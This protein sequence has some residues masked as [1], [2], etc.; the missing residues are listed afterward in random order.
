MDPLTHT[1]VGA[2]LSATRLGEK[3]R[4]AAAALVVGANLPDI[5]GVCYMIDGDLAL[6]FRRGWTHGILALGVLPLILTGIFLLLDRLRPGERRVDA[7]WMLALSAISIWSHPALDWLN[8]YGMRWLMPFSG[9]WFYGD[10]VFIMD[11]WLWLVL[12]VGYLAGRRSTPVLVVTG[13]VLGAWIVRTVSR[14]APEYLPLLLAVV[15]VLVLALL[16]KTPVER[17]RLGQLFAAVALVVACAYIGARIALNEATEAAVARELTGRGHAVATVMAGP[18]P[19][20]PLQWSIVARTGD[21]YRYG[22]YDWRTGTL[23]MKE[24]TEEAARDSEEWRRAKQ[25][26]S[27]QGLVTWLRFPAYEVE[28]RGA[29]TL[30]HIYDARRMGG[31]ARG[32]VVLKD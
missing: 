6:G 24:P 25:D 12:G 28:R 4:F 32:T 22:E 21:T 8:T 9:K 1:L 7:R 16:W 15:V 3:T 2:N 31:W 18:H 5:D 13:L 11:V 29:E 23:T 26:P 30:V 27:V 20:S 19:I 17:P 14:R 10:A